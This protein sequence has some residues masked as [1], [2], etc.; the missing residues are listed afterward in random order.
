MTDFKALIAS[1]LEKHGPNC[2]ICDQS[3]PC[4]AA[5]ALEA[6]EVAVEALNVDG[7]SVLPYWRRATAA[8]AKIGEVLR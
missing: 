5:K 7:I 6:L 1:R 3:E 2:A 8:L 4:D